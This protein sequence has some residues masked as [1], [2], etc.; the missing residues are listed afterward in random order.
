MTS[1]DQLRQGQRA[2]IEAL[3]GGGSLSLRLMEMGLLG[4]GRSKSSL[5]PPWASH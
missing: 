1:L 2:R 4:R 5:W 3:H